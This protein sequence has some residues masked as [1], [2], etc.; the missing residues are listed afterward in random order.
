MLGKLV[1][2]VAHLTTEIAPGQMNGDQSDYAC[3]MPLRNPS[4]PS[5]NVTCTPLFGPGYGQCNDRTK[6]SAGRDDVLPCTENKNLI[7]PTLHST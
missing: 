4:P 7:F 3:L 2:R 6:S 1:K 5:V